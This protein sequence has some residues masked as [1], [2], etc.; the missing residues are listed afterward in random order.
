MNF[1]AEDKPSSASAKSGQS[2]QA[3]APKS[4]TKPS[5]N[6]FGSVLKIFTFL[7]P[8]VLILIGLPFLLYKLS[9]LAQIAF[10]ATSFTIN[11]RTMEVLTSKRKPELTKSSSGITNALVVG[12]DDRGGDSTLRNTDTI[13]L[14]SYNHHLNSVSMLSFP[15]DIIVSYPGSYGSG[16]INSV[17]LTGE[18]NKKGTGLSYLKQTIE[19]LTGQKIHYYAMINIVGFVEVVDLL[20]GVDITVERAFTASYPKRGGWTTVSFK[21]GKQHMNGARAL[22]YARARYASGVEGSDFA[23]ARRQQKL[24]EAVME[25]AK[26]QER[27]HNPIFTY[28]VLKN[29][30]R[31]IQTSSMTPEDVQA[32]IN[33]ILNAKEN[34]IKIYKTVLDPTAGNWKLLQESSYGP[35]GYHI[36]PKAG[37]NNWTQIK[38]YVKDYLL[39]PSIPNT[40]PSV[41]IYNAGN[42]NFATKFSQINSRFYYLNVHNAGNISGKYKGKL[43]FSNKKK[44]NTAA[45][46]MADI[47]KF[48]VGDKSQYPKR[49]KNG[50]ITII[51]GK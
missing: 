19:K 45:E 2:A 5:K 13:M 1:S 27:F 28:K 11:A 9:D 39:H 48:E 23:R 18:N 36:T 16:K 12:I 6:L 30:A 25:K 17:Y 24:I 43:V 40:N 3:L 8:V 7:I 26:K 44:S 38:K 4:K 46:D 34:P 32:S 50:H 35:F 22:K 41:Y 15:R 20:G 21:A 51:L 42:S 49:P 47:L 33:I 14:I 37:Q 10:G 29:I 31:K